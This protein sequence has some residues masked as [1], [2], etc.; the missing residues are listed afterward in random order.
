MGN[1]PSRGFYDNQFHNFPVNYSVTPEE[2][3][4]HESWD[5]LMPVIE[6]IIEKHNSQCYFEH[7]SFL[8]VG[9]TYFVMLDDT[10]MKEQ[11]RGDTMIDAAYKAVINY[12]SK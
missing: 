12:V 2:L 11:G 4:Y 6:K 9:Q 1:T 8:N 5:W 7:P 10:I 3:A